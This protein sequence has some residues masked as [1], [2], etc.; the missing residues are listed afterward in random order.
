M[1][2]QKVTKMD[3]ARKI[4]AEVQNQEKPRRVFMEKA[5]EAGL[6]KA[7]AS[8]YFQ[9]LRTEAE[10]GDAYQHHRKSASTSVTSKKKAAKAGKGDSWGVYDGEKLVASATSRDKARAE[11]KNLG[12]GFSVRKL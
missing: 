2:E 1:T 3:M 11:S 5:Q 12:G 7:G 6:S 4:F 10:G 9:M 8:S